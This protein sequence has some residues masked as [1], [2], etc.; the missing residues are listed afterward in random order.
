MIETSRQLMSKIA[1]LDFEKIW[2][3]FHRLPFVLYDS[4]RCCAAGR[5]QA[6]DPAMIGNTAIQWNGT[7]TAIWNLEL[8]P[9]DD[10]DLLAA[11][12][13]HEMFHAYQLELGES[14]WPD[15][16]VLLNTKRTLLDLQLECGEYAALAGTD[17]PGSAVACAAALHKARKASGGA[18]LREQERLETVEGMA[19]YAGLC[20]LEQL[21]PEKVRARLEQFRN[22]LRD[23]QRL[24]E[25]PRLVSYYAGAMRLWLARSAGIPMSHSVGS[26]TQTVCELLIP[27][28]P[29]ISAVQ[30]P[31]AR[32]LS[33]LYE[34]DAACRET[35]ICKAAERLRRERIGSFRIAGYDPM[36]MLRSGDRILCSTFVRLEGNGQTYSFAGETLLAMETGADREV[37]AFFRMGETD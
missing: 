34:K 29:E 37:C 32:T 33:E 13:I 28:V 18:W 24:L 19:E 2:P 12:I 23:P 15:D 3:G 27:A 7:P 11:N 36:N 30:L 1:Q 17:A 20:A 26:E 10:L 5:V 8:D 22:V 9:C 21:A 16:L 14:R 6:R 4:E 35:C 31:D 25:Q